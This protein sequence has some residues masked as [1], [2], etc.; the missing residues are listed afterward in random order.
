M[1][2]ILYLE[3]FSG[4]S[5]DMSVAALL[6]LGVDVDVLTASLKS[7]PLSGYEIVISKI[8][9]SGLVMTDFDVKL[10]QVHENHDHDMSYLHGHE[11]N[12]GDAEHGHEHNH[13]HGQTHAHRGLSE[14]MAILEAGDLTPG[15]LEL[16][17]KIFMILAQAEAQVHG[18]SIEQVHF[19]EVGAVDSIVD[20]AAFAICLD[21]LK[22]DQVVVSPLYEGSGTI[23]CQHGIIPVP[24]P[25]V[26]QIVANHQ[27]RLH[28]T[29]V[30]GELV[31]PTGAAIVAAVQTG[32]QLPGQYVI[33]GIGMGAGKRHYHGA[34]GF[35]RAM[36]LHTDEEAAY[37]DMIWK[38]ESNIDDSTGESLGYL[39]DCLMKAGAKD[40]NY[41]PVFMKK[42]RPGYQL[43]VICSEEQREK[44][45]N[46]I[47]QES[48]TIGIRRMELERTV[49]DRAF[50][51]VKTKYGEATV[52]ICS[53]GDWQK[54]YPEYEDAAKIARE[55]GLPL[56]HVYDVICE[57]A[58]NIRRPE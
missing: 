14:I 42:N 24:V 19:H 18:K 13:D 52:K 56:H 5:G 9:K 41:T 36:L 48:T 15:A 25:A 26:S 10:D 35:L 33:D 32:S 51:K 21:W 57:A 29:G 12:H 4:I 34:P 23:R 45:E 47:F 44:L 27:L 6:D 8:N 28:M 50:A 53:K 7:L 37:R 16:A 11:H 22:P 46:I 30:Q 43:N 54:V 39:M 31:T 17:K 38:L 40:V 58:S 20:I 2:K 55:N 49:L 1:E 3:C